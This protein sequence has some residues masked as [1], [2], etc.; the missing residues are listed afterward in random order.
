[1]QKASR[2]KMLFVIS[3]LIV[4]S[5]WVVNENFKLKEKVDTVKH[6]LTLSQIQ[7][8]LAQLDG[9]IANQ[10]EAQ[11]SQPSYVKSLSQPN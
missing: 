2:N 9:A 10:I 5:V 6:R 1:M 7:W 4:F 11:W 3:L 8:D